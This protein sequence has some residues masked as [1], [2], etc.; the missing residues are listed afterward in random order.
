MKEVT[1]P[2]LFELQVRIQGMQFTPNAPFLQWRLVKAWEV[3][4]VEDTTIYKVEIV[5][6]NMIPLRG[7]LIWPIE[8]IYLDWQSMMFLVNQAIQ[9]QLDAFNAGYHW[10]YKGL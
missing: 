8:D 9:A 5:S 3:T 7:I 4:I 10:R 6:N 1:N 2:R